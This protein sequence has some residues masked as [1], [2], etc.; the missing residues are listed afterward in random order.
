M[1]S[2]IIALIDVLP[3]L[4]IFLWNNRFCTFGIKK[5]I[6]GLAIL[7]FREKRKQQTIEFSFWVKKKDKNKISTEMS[8]FCLGVLPNDF[9]HI[10]HRTTIN[11]KPILKHIF[12]ISLLSDICQR[13]V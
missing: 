6:C 11:K 1:K 13:S 4:E 10:Y 12:L 8:L 3:R 7:L 9:M 5:R 2:S